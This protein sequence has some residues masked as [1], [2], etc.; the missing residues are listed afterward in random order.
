[1]KKG[2]STLLEQFAPE[3]EAG[4]LRLEQLKLA[5]IAILPA[6]DSQ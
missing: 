1:M 2:V 5:L 4:E 6:F 3:I